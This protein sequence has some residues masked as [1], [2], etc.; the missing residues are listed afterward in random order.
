MRQMALDFTRA[1]A[2]EL[3]SPEIWLRVLF[4]SKAARSGAVIQRN[5]RDIERFA[6]WERFL[7][8]VERRGFQAVENAGQVVIFCNRAPIRTV[9]R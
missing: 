9:T 1:I 4:S 7:R 2:P 3:Y 8:E 5:M 6:G